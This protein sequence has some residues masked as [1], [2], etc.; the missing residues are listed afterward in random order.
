M[1]EGQQQLWK[2]RNAK[3]SKEFSRRYSQKYLESLTFQIASNAPKAG[4]MG[5][6]M[7]S[8][9][10]KPT[11]CENW[12]LCDRCAFYHGTLRLKQYAEIF[13]HDFRFFFVTLGC[14]GH[15]NFASHT[16]EKCR[17][18]WDANKQLIKSLHD[19]HFINGAY[20]VH[21]IKVSS[22]LPLTANPHSHALV[23]SNY[24]LNEVEQQIQAIAQGAGLSLQPSIRITE[25][26]DTDQDREKVI[27]YLTKSIDLVP[28]YSSAWNAHCLEN[29]DR[30]PEL[31]VELRE[32]FD[33]IAAAFDRYHKIHYFGNL[34]AQSKGFIGKSKKQVIKARKRAKR[35]LKWKGPMH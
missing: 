2:I 35:K 34:M 20:L 13:D 15:L 19:T 10:G 32:C 9:L 22:F 21:E 17:P 3:A 26:G 5:Y 27:R 18:F 24:P 7:N 23:I 33:A 14:D 28:A 29:R 12:L 31:N 11:P 8:N 16:A 1:D 30:A 25:I 6:C 4:K